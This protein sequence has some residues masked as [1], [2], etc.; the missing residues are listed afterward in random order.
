MYMYIRYT[1]ISYVY[2]E[3]SIN[4]YKDLSYI[5]IKSRA[6]RAYREYFKVEF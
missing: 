1:Y 6:Y 5:L 3:I 2:N 4:N